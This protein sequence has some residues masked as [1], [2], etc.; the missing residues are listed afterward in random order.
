LVAEKIDDNM[1]ALT[2]KIDI[3]SAAVTSSAGRGSGL[4][5]WLELPYRSG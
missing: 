1:K 5:V 2:E 3:L 4:T